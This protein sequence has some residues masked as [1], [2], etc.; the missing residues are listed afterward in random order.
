[1]R[2]SECGSW[3]HHY[4]WVHLC[5]IKIERCMNAPYVF[6]KCWVEERDPTRGCYVRVDLGRVNT[7]DRFYEIL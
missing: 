5:T 2:Q 7:N 4:V 1:M 3:H 6:K